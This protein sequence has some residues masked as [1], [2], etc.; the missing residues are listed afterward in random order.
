MEPKPARDGTG[1]ARTG[2]IAKL[3][4]FLIDTKAFYAGVSMGLLTLLTHPKRRQ[5]NIP[6]AL[7]K[8]PRNWITPIAWLFKHYARDER[9]KIKKKQ[10]KEREKKKVLKNYP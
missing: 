5:P 8:C 9:V 4:F 6:Y 7:K 3:S 10:R 2:S 1:R